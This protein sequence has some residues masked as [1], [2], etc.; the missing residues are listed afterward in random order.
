MRTKKYSDE[1]YDLD[2][3]WMQLR[4]IPKVTAKEFIDMLLKS[5]DMRTK[6]VI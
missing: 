6:K 4:G 3:T 2:V 1:D 5:K